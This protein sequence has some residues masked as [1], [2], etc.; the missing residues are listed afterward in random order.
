MASNQTSED[1]FEGFVPTN[2][3]TPVSNGDKLIARF[4]QEISQDSLDETLTR[5]E[6]ATEP[7]VSNILAVQTQMPIEIQQNETIIPET[8]QNDSA[9]PETQD[10][11]DTPIPRAQEN[12]PQTFIKTK[13]P[14]LNET[15]VVRANGSI[16]G[17]NNDSVAH[18]L[19]VRNAWKLP[20][21]MES[22]KF[23]NNSKYECSI[24]HV[25]IKI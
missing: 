8:K 11:E 14:V 22:G 15:F 2:F 23:E 9:I 4:T 1:C 18:A 25:Y 6:N 21:E 16:D 12:Q 3:S 10:N 20:E 13:V 17:T 5:N 24:N 19:N 7:E